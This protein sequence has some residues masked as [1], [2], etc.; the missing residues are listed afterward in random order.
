MGKS[1][2]SAPIGRHPCAACDGT[3]QVKVRSGLAPQGTTENCGP[4]GGTGER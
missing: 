2:G 3:G 4:C 1:N